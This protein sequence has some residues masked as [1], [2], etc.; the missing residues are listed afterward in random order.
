MKYFLTSLLLSITLF[1][2]TVSS[3]STVDITDKKPQYFSFFPAVAYLPESSWL[4]AASLMLYLNPL[5]EEFKK[6]STISILLAASIRK[7]ITLNIDPSLY[8]FKDKILIRGTSAFLIW[9]A[10][11]YGLGFDSDT[12]KRESYSAKGALWD[13]G[14]QYAAI[15]GLLVGPSFRIGYEKIQTPKGS[16]LNSQEV[17]GRRGGFFN[18]MGAVISYDVRDSIFWTKKGVFLSYRFLV[19]SP[20]WF[21]SYSYYDHRLDTRFFISPIKKLT[22]GF[23]G[24][25]KYQTGAPYFRYIATP[26]IRAL[27]EG[28]YRDQFLIQIRNELRFPMIGRFYGTGFFELA[29]LSHSPGDWKIKNFKTSTGVGLRFALNPTEIVN[30]RLDVAYVDGSVNLELLALERF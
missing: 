10:R 16:L 30:L 27:E 15:K 21:S 9:P 22:Y 20:R 18:G 5:R 8:V 17:S 4:A 3:N 19:D 26:N 29:N 6:P 28:R 2:S 11:F 13:G 14:V 7:Q 23:Q 1:A 12:E 24:E 25:V